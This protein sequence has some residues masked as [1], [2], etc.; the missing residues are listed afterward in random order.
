MEGEDG[1]IHT[2]EGI[3]MI[4]LLSMAGVAFGKEARRQTINSYMLIKAADKYS[5]LYALAKVDTFMS[6]KRMILA[7]TKDGQPLPANFGPLQIITTGEK[8]HA[9]LIR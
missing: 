9:R 3:D 7:Y 2:Y 8:K 6:A 4:T 5:V 1:M